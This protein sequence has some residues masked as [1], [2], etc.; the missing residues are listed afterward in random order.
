MSTD[1][2]Q[3]EPTNASVNAD[4][5]VFFLPPTENPHAHPGQRGWGRGWQPAAALADPANLGGSL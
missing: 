2:Q 5:H 3:M 4:A 1:D